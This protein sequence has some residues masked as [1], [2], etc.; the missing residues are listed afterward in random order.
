MALHKQYFANVQKINGSVTD[1]LLV[2]RAIFDNH[3]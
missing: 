3:D 1:K 2:G